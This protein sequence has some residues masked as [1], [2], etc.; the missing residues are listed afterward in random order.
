MLKIDDLKTL[1][2]AYAGSGGLTLDEAL[3]RIDSPTDEEL[4]E[5]AVAQMSN[6]DRNAR[7]LALRVLRRQHGMRAMRGVLAGLND[8]KRRV[9]AVAIQACPNYL[10][11]TPSWRRSKPSPAISH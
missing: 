6:P 10:A 3:R 4:I 9:C 7:A 1:R 5:F 8:E 2:E 11:H